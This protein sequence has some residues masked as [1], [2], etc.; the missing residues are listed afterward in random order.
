M[1]GD[2]QVR[3]A[4][5][6][7]NALLSGELPV[8]VHSVRAAAWVART[9]LEATLVELVRAKGCDPG[10]ATARTMLGCVES[11][12]ADDDPQIAASAQYTWDRLSE[13][14]HHHAYELAPTH[15]EVGVLVAV[16][17][18][19]GQFLGTANDQGT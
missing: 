3:D 13:A 17:R 1:I 11:L 16:V 2:A 6:Q 19:I 9:A 12:Y 4:L 10:D 8:R 15:V 14:S 18:S 7:A 5:D